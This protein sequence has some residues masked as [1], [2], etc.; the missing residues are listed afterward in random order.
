M[1]INCTAS[2]SAASC[3]TESFGERSETRPGIVRV[4]DSLLST[5]D[6]DWRGLENN[7]R[8]RL[9]AEVPVPAD[10]CDCRCRALRSS[11]ADPP[12]VS[13][14]VAPLATVPVLAAFPVPLSRVAVPCELLP[15]LVVPGRGGLMRKPTRTHRTGNAPCGQVV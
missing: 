3:A 2:W 12:S 10:D 15:A 6:L 4:I 1:P 5:D 11:I 7:A 14:G 13:M 8:I 9:K